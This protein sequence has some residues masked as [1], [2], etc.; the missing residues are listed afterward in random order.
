MPRN[1]AVI[2][3]LLS[4]ALPNA[5]AL[6]E[7][8]PMRVSSE[9]NF[10]DVNEVVVGSFIV[11]FIYEKRD[12]LSVGGGGSRNSRVDLAGVDTPDFQAVTDQAY[13]D[14]VASL[15]AGGIAVRDRA[16]FASALAAS[17]AR[18]LENGDD[19]SLPFGRDEGAKARLY[20]PTGFGGVYP[21]R[22]F[23]AF[24]GAGIGTAFAMNG[25]MTSFASYA[26]DNNVPVV[27]AIYLIDYADVEKYRSVFGSVSSITTSTSLAVA[28]D[29]TQLALYNSEGR[30]GTITMRT[31]V[32]S[33]GAY[34]TLEDTTSG[35]QRAA[36]IV[37]GIF[38]ALSGTGSSS[39]RRL[40]YTAE[41]EPWRR[42]VADL[43]RRTS[44]Q[45]AARLVN[46]AAQ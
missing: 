3:I 35:S 21:I 8:E 4:F 41:A 39:G 24:S 34:G 7:R 14:F 37:G 12:R 11:A 27:S 5:A 9:R 20:S 29:K 25:V 46:A 26:R 18:P 15:E 36:N 30:A 33:P 38:G 45:F 13:A 42:G 19:R 17:S 31:A 23:E 44:E 2:A 32:A 43:A 40:T 10:A 6:A 28:E 16:G 22:D 1:I